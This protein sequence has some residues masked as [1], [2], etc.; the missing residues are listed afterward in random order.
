MPHLALKKAAEEAQATLSIYGALRS[1]LRTEMLKQASQRQKRGIARFK[2]LARAQQKQWKRPIAQW[3]EEMRKRTAAGLRQPAD[4][5][6]EMPTIEKVLD[7]TKFDAWTLNHFKPILG[8]T[9]RAGG[10]SLFRAR[11]LIKQDGFDPITAAAV[12]WINE[13]GLEL[14]ADINGKTKEGV[15]QLIAQGIKA[16][17]HPRE[18]AREIRSY[19]GVTGKMAQALA[20]REE[21]II[22]NRPDLGPAAISNAMDAYARKQIRRRAETIARTE[23]ASGLNEGI[24]QSYG[25][26]GY[27]KLQR[28]EDPVGEDEWNCDCREENGTV[29]TLEES[30]G[31]LPAHPN[32]EGTWVAYID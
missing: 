26:M 29:Y 4:T 31:I 17:K 3:L 8:D 28:V 14:V 32:C 25:Q 27:T 7:W 22:L 1:S 12:A 6:A 13:H 9:L 15:I 10:D 5:I 16:G 19:I 18:I 23:T 11:R 2:K 30:Q 20:N 21:W 24:R